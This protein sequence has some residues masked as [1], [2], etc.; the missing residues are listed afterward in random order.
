MDGPYS[1]AKSFPSA[2]D[3]VI[4]CEVSE[5]SKTYI[6]AGGGTGG[7]IYPGV[8]VARALKLKNPN[9][10]VIFVGT[11]MGLETKIVPREGFRLELIEVGKL[12]H[13]GGLLGKLKTLL[14]LPF[15]FFQSF[16]ILKRLEPAAVLGV[17]GYASGPLVLMA[18]FMG[19][20]T[21]IWEANSH[22]GMTNRWLSRFVRKSYLVFEEA[23]SLLHSSRVQVMGLPVRA[24]IENPLAPTESSA[25]R[26]LVVGGSQGSRAINDCVSAALTLG[27]PWLQGVKFIHQSGVHDIES[28]KRRYQ[29]L[30]SSVE[31]FDFLYDMN[32]QYA[33][34][35]LVICR[36]GASTVA[37]L[38]AG[39]KVALV[40]PLPTAADNHQQKNAETLVK[41]NAGTMLLQKDLTPERLVAEIQ[42]LRN[43]PELRKEMSANIRRLFIP[44]AAQ[45][46]AQD[47]MEGLGT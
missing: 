8:A 45:N 31:V 30:E 25:F 32:I 15:G 6:I 23:R 7:H 38:A 41:N 19:F 3:E 17:G 9:C 46:M 33:N 20:R 40:I 12:N 44:H 13:G 11:A 4:F 10:E 5:K 39:G 22:P 43:H 2:A 24:E 47:L 34:C 28:L 29:G 36:G 16:Q 37:E 27:G 14:R 35:D 21:A 18:S 26:I 1:A 42:H